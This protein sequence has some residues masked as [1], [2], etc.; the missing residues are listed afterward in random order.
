MGLLE[1]KTIPKIII[2]PGD[3]DGI[4]AEITVKAL[5]Q[6][7]QSH[8]LPP[9]WVW[10]APNVQL[11]L[12]K[13]LNRLFQRFVCN[14][15]HFEDSLAATW[16]SQTLIE[17]ETDIEPHRWFERSVKACQK[18]LA[19]G[20]VTGPLSK[21]TP[22]SDD[23]CPG[24]TAILRKVYPQ[25][26]LHMGFVGKYFN[27]VLATDHIPIKNVPSSLNPTILQQSLIAA[28]TLR[29][30]LPSRSR[31]RPLG[32]VGLNPHAGEKGIL[33]SEE[34]THF[35]TALQWAR[36]NN[37]SV[38]GPLVPDVAFQKRNWTR[39]S[40]YVCPYH[41]QALIPFKLIHGFKAVHITIGL[42]FTRTSVDHGT[43]KDIYGKNQAVS[44][45]MKLAIRYAIDA[46]K[47]KKGTFREKK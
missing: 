42:P 34:Q 20:I 2:T 10:R 32:L 15:N 31:N 47:N 37:I 44:D 9:L 39:Y 35:T 4:G 1:Y 36:N 14:E 41:D 3:I 46:T 21:S 29:Q 16:A 7:G 8:P 45:S 26:P 40:V 5:L 23:G 11:K 13:S 43:A 18:R 19:G 28:E 6:M 17:V 24:H 33:G 38:A 30:G 12:W 25:L 22:Y 27:A